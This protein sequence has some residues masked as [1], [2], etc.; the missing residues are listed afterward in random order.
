MVRLLIFLFKKPFK[1]H[2]VAAKDHAAHDGRR[3]FRRAAGRSAVPAGRHHG[4]VHRA[5]HPVHHQA[6]DHGGARGLRHPGQHPPDHH[7]PDHRPPD[8]AARDAVWPPREL[9]GQG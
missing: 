2:P 5:P 6:A 3:E 7:Q 4:R 8:R 1:V 9:P